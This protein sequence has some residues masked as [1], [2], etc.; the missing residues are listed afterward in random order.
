QFAPSHRATRLALTPPALVNSP[1]TMRLPLYTVKAL[2]AVLYVPAVTPLPSACQRVP[3][4]WAMLLAKTPPARV[5]MPPA[6]RLPLYSA[7]AWTEPLIP[8]TPS[9]GCQ[10]DG[11]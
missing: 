10:A 4:H 3:S 2:T 8:G 5:K 6:V 11:H 7:T 1:A 9:P